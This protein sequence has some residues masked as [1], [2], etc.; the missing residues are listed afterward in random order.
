M[1]IKQWK[2]NESPEQTHRKIPLQFFG[3]RGE[4]SFQYSFQ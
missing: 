1:D 2:Q 4:L 3:G